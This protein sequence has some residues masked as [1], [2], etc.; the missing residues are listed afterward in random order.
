MQ[1]VE[2]RM[3]DLIPAE[4]N[5]RQMTA[6]QNE[7]L[8]ASMKR[9]GCVEPILV[10]MHK[11]RKNIIIGGHQRLRVWKSLGNETIPCVEIEVDRDRERELN[12][13]LNLNTGEFDIDILAN[14]FDIGELEDWGFDENELFGNEDIPEDN[15]DIDEDAM[16]ETENECP[17]CGFKW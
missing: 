3:E 6:K 1:T 15:K 8:K 11:D 13:R 17:K 7:D 14:E 9:F 16:A 12:V 10:N 4:Y 5:P 2:R